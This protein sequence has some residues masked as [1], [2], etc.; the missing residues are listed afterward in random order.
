MA[1]LEKIKAT[2]NEETLAFISDDVEKICGHKAETYEEYLQMAEWMTDV[3]LGAESELKPL[4]EPS[5]ATA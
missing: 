1:A 5:A 3:E 4:V 2:G